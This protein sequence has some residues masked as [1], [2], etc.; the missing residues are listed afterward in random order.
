MATSRKNTKQITFVHSESESYA[1]ELLSSLLKRN[2]YDT[3]LVFDHRLFDS[4]EVKNSYLHNVFDIQDI[5]IKQVIET[6][7]DL[8]AFSVF[9]YN[10]QWALKMAR[11]IKK[12]I[13]A[14]IIFGGIHPTLVPEI[15]IQ[16]D[17]VDIVCVGE[18]E[19][20]L[21]ELVENLNSEKKYRI[22]NLWFKKDGKIIKNEQRPLF[23]NLDSLPLPDKD[24]FASYHP[25][26]NSGY[27]LVVGRGCPFKCSFC[28]ANALKQVMGDKGHY[29]RKRSVDHVIA[30][31]VW[32][33]KRFKPSMVTF[34]DDVFVINMDWLKEFVPKYKKFIN[35]PFNCDAHPA[36]VTQEMVRLLKEAGCDLLIFGV[37]S[38]SERIRKEILKRPE[39]NAQIEKAIS[40]CRAERLSFTV[41]HILNIPNDTN[42]DLVE[43]VKFYNEL[44]PTV[45]NTFLLTYYPKAEITEIAYENKILSKHDLRDIDDGKIPA[46]YSLTLGGRRENPSKKGKNNTDQFIF[47]L[48]LLPLL[49]KSLV[50]QII[51]R[52]YLRR[53]FLAP[54]WMIALIKFLIRIKIG[55]PFDT[56]YIFR[57]LFKRIFVN[58]KIKYFLVPKGQLWWKGHI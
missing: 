42:N 45:I 39:T 2:G 3:A 6:K 48:N 27:G 9:T 1:L 24:L 41:D 30:E 53:N 15:V 52:G 8:I 31:L 4:S 7:P 17:C 46:T 40:I 10:Y 16:N 18:G 38:T 32:A 37:Q 21:M 19:E 11:A 43:A 47:W 56:I 35:L 57:L 13:N 34:V 58:L 49:P 33:K 22:R 20:A 26:Y 23:E 25:I 51:K 44:R 5:L 54:I 14:P 55:R 29:I 28:C 50:N 12:E 36:G